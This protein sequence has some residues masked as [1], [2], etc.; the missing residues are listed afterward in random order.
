MNKS[1]L[2]EHILGLSTQIDSLK[3]VNYMLEESKDSLLLNVSLLGSA[4]E[5][6][7]IEISRLSN[8]V[9]INNQEIERLQ[10]D[11]DNEITNLN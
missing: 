3:D 1:N 5:V 11:Y 9:V 8:L 2:K 6:N 7:E 4:N 10:S